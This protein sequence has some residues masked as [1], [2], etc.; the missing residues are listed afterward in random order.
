MSII[1][2][3]LQQEPGDEGA[4]LCIAGLYN[5]NGIFLTVLIYINIQLVAHRSCHICFQM[6]S[7]YTCKCVSEN[8]KLC[9]GTELQ[10]D[11]DVTSDG[12]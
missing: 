8:K 9:M 5:D 10:A 1:L 12:W 4:F 3:C 6:F 11:V 2:T 7:F